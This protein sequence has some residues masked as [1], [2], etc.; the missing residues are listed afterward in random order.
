M[1]LDLS[2]IHALCFDVDG[3]LRDTDDQYVQRLAGWLRPLRRFLPGRDEKAAARWLVMASEDPGRFV[4]GLPD[5]LGIDD[6]LA[7]LGNWFYQRGPARHPE[8]FLM[9]PGVFEL[10]Q[11][12]RPHYPMAIVTARGERA[13]LAFLESFNLTPFFDQIACAQTCEYTKPYPDPVLW[14]AKRMGIDPQN[15]LMI[16]DT[17]ADIRAGLAA[18][19]QTTGVLCGFGERLELEQSGAHLILPGTAD[20]GPV[21]L[22]QAT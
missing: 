7:R 15:C 22:G 16:G 2:R 1:P 10:L 19:A 18:G 20:L 21:L 13:T 14:A 6:E 4:H 8:T 3:T 9:I 5:R 17:V 11:A 12:L